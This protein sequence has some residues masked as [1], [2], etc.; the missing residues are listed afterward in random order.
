MILLRSSNYYM[1]VC[2]PQQQSIHTGVGVMWGSRGGI[3]NHDATTIGRVFVKGW[4]GTKGFQPL[5]LANPI[6]K[7]EG[8]LTRPLLQAASTALMKYGSL[9][10]EKCMSEK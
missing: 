1:A 3:V 6:E 4:S 10:S 8:I 2:G 9:S 7:A 5:P